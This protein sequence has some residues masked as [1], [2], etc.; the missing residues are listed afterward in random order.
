MTERADPPLFAS[1]AGSIG[2]SVLTLLLAGA[3]LI[4]ADPR[5]QAY[6]GERLAGLAEALR[7]LLPG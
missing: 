1:I 4:L 2:L 7:G 3:L 6:W 5:T